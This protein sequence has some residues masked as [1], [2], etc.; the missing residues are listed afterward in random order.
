MAD[1]TAPHQDHLIFRALRPVYAALTPV[2]E[3]VMR[4]VC[5]AL[6]AYHGSGKIVA[7]FGAAEMVEQIGFVP[8]WFWS[9]LLSVGEFGS[10]ILLA[11]GFLTR[12]AAVVAS[13]I[14]LVTI[15][16]HWVVLAQGID[17]AEKSI[18]WTTITLFFVFRGAN[19]L[20][21]DRALGRAF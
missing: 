8:G 5:G 10:G 19:L 16:F 6:L 14:L 21:V 13:V 18:L 3:T 12:P 9:V 2:A 4:F 1:V 20:S 17:G 15:Y 7:P 11:L